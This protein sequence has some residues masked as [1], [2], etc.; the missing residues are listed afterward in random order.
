MIEAALRQYQGASRRPSEI[1][2]LL[3]YS[4]SMQGEGNEQMVASL[5]TLLIDDKARSFF[6][7]TASGDIFHVI[8]FNSQAG[9]VVTAT[10]ASK[11]ELAGLYDYIRRIGPD[12]GTNIYAAVASGLE[13]LAQSGNKKTHSQM[14][15]LLT[16]GV[17]D[18]EFRDL[19]PLL[20]PSPAKNVP[21]FSILFGDASE[22]QVKR[23]AEATAARVFDG[24]KGLG[25]AF[26]Q[27]RGYAN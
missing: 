6:L 10:G 27:A 13:A 24:R 14:V 26:R 12:G 2:F 9:S 4:G 16:D 7:E 19:A 1:A 23:I 15:L 3:D 21:V 25:D 20:D 22:E 18:G 11:D 17:S 5:G 8:P